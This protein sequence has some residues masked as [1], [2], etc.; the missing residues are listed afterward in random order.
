MKNL[1]MLAIIGL[2]LTGFSL[3]SNAQ[4]KHSCRV[5]DPTGT[6]L[7]VHASPIDGKVV[8]KLKNGTI[9]RVVDYNEMSGDETAFW[10]QISV[11]K[12]GK[13]KTIGWVTQKFLQCGEYGESQ[14]QRP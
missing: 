11:L 3:T 14:K 7:N 5:A 6:L 9:V 13:W 4:N 12:N 8:A 2:C 10:W 1:I